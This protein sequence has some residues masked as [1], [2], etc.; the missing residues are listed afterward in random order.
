MTSASGKGLLS[1]GVCKRSPWPCCWLGVAGLQKSNDCCVWRL[2]PE[3]GPPS[4]SPAH[5]T[6][7][8]RSQKRLNSAIKNLD[9]EGMCSHFGQ[10]MNILQLLVVAVSSRCKKLN[11][12]IWMSTYNYYVYYCV[13]LYDTSNTWNR[14]KDNCEVQPNEYIK[15][16][17]EIKPLF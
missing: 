4:T 10:S 16:L 1:L 14:I 8:S 2:Q 7:K 13:C 17:H 3:V 9:D 11:V 6:P 15:T 12:G 5:R